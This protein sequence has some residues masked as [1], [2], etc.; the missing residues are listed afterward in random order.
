[1]RSLPTA[2]ACFPTVAHIEAIHRY[3]STSSAHAKPKEHGVG[4]TI[5]MQSHT[6]ARR[7]RRAAAIIE[8][9]KAIPCKRAVTDCHAHAHKEGSHLRPTVAY[10]SN[11]APCEFQPACGCSQRKAPSTA[12]GASNQSVPPTLY[13]ARWRSQPRNPRL[14]PPRGPARGAHMRGL[15]TGLRLKVARLSPR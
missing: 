10:Y 5:L 2:R 9:R 6:F 7:V 8:S 13:L 4:N 12:R 11:V 15:H 3:P 14:L 1:M